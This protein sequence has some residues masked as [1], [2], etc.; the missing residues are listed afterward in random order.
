MSLG[1]K[2]LLC[3][4]GTVE[5]QRNTRFKIKVEENLI[6][7]LY[8]PALCLKRSLSALSSLLLF[9]FFSAYFIVSHAGNSGRLT[10]VRYCSRKSSA[11]HSYQCVQ[12]F[13]M[14]KQWYGCQCLGFLTCTQMLMQT[15]A[16]GGCTDTARESAL[17]AD[18]GRK[19]PC[20]TGDSNPRQ[21]CAWLFSHALYLLRYSPSP[22]SVVVR[23]LI[24]KSASLVR[25]LPFLWNVS[26]LSFLLLLLSATLPCPLASVYNLSK[27]LLLYFSKKKGAKKLSSPERTE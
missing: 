9:L 15:I 26:M 14:S 24:L 18:T 3:P 16:H 10:W 20:C 27:L 19:I 25:F 13:S 21:Y 8:A 4:R 12:Y 6:L 5:Q 2:Y 1:C 22:E 11:T 17:K 23:S 7:S